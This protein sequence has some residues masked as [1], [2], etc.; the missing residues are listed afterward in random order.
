MPWVNEGGFLSSRKMLLLWSLL[1]RAGP[2]LD[3]LQPIP[4][5]AKRQVQ[6]RATMTGAGGWLPGLSLSRYRTRMIRAAVILLALTLPANAQLQ[7]WEQKSPSASDQLQRLCISCPIPVGN[8]PLPDMPSEVGDI[9]YRHE[10][11]D[12]RHMLR[13]ST[14]D[15]IIDSDGWRGSRLYAFANRVADQTC[16][17]RFTMF[18]AVRLTTTVRQFSFRCV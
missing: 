9:W 10:V 3:L 17:G 7:R 1:H 8:P 15:L 18:K 5:M 6:R 12:G 4:L 11:L 14:T 13:L 16:N 2:G